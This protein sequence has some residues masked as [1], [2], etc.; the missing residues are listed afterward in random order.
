VVDLTTFSILHIIERRMMQCVV[1][2]ELEAMRKGAAVA[3]LRNYSS[4]SV[5]EINKIMATI[6][7]R[8]DI[9]TRN[10]LPTNQKCHSP[11]WDVRLQKKHFRKWRLIT[12]S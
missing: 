10:F 6:S 7:P 11:R 2:N 3:L 5:Q 9:R 1:N 12:H 8:A 4:I